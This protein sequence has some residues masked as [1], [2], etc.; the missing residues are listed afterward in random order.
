MTPIAPAAQ[1]P[2]LRFPLY[3]TKVSAGFPSPADDYLE[4]QLDLNDLCVRHKEA[5]FFLWLQGDSMKNANMIDGDLLVVDRSIVPAHL[6]IVVAVVNAELV[7]KYL[8][9]RRDEV[10]LVPANEDYADIDIPAGSDLTVWGVVT[11]VVH[12]FG[13]SV[14]A[15]RRK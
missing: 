8:W 9:K 14:R 1:P 6:D 5:T 13:K 10:K 4:T 7:V 2:P 15:G 3:A 12:S 11:H